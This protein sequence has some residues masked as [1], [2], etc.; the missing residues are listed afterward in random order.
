[1]IQLP[2]VIIII[3]L[4][5]VVSGFRPLDLS[6]VNTTGHPE[7]WQ[8]KTKRFWGFRNPTYAES[9]A[10]HHIDP[11]GQRKKHKYPFWG[12]TLYG[13]DDNYYYP[14]TQRFLSNNRPHVK[15]PTSTDFNKTTIPLRYSGHT[16]QRTP[17]KTGLPSLFHVRQ[18]TI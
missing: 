14:R 2:I 7:P 5:T 13:F 6:Q 17:D 3:I 4:I 10:S 9:T 18:R 16:K 11:S 15:Y 8:S 12:Y 1:M